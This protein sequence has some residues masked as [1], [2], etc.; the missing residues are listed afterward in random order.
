MLLLVGMT[1]LVVFDSVR[2][3]F[4][5]LSPDGQ[6]STFMWLLLKV[7]LVSLGVVGAL[8]LLFPRL[9]SVAARIDHWVVTT[10]RR[11]FLWRVVAAAFLIRL[12]VVVVMPFNLWQDYQCYDDLGWR[13][14]VTGGYSTGDHLTAY[15]PPGYPFWLSRLYLVFGHEPLACVIANVFFGTATVLLSYL[16]VRRLWG[17]RIGRWTLLGMAVF[18]SQVLFTSVLASE[19]LFTPLFVA[20]ILFFV[21]GNRAQRWWPTV[22]LGG[23]TLGLAT[24]T[25]TVTTLFLIPVALYWLVENKSWRSTGSRL[26]FALVGFLLVATPWMIRNYHA[27]GEICLSTNSGVNLFIGN[28][29]GSG[30]GYSHQVV[31]QL[32]LSESSQEARVN[33]DAGKRARDYIAQYP[34][35]FLG[36]GLTKVAYLYATD[37]D[38]LDFVLLPPGE[39]RS[40]PGWVVL[41]VIVQSVYLTVL[42][43]AILALPIVLRSRIHRS[44]PTT[45][46][47]STIA[48]WTALHFV[49]FAV[50]R[51][52]FPIIPLLA[53]LAAVALAYRIDMFS[54]GTSACPKQF[55]D[56]RHR[57]N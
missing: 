48:Y 44:G 7:F 4:L 49:F 56:K 20:A 9:L 55:L 24:L 18:P 26:A 36:R 21:I 38:P 3:F 46:V 8:M 30:I 13:W 6:V 34:L 43:L 25:R 39:T 50:G 2:G 12:F 32:D 53:A 11:L 54:L 52:H 14:A 15:W 33:N 41:A 31:G 47:L 10:D 17:E 27:V 16:L 57:E 51:F 37:V 23:I 5:F 28:Q 45:L 42:L 19:M 22:L 29:P 1:A 40:Q 35:A